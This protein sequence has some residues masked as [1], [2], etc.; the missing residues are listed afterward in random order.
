MENRSGSRLTNILQINTVYK[1]NIDEWP[2]C[3]EIWTWVIVLGIWFLI[4]H[5]DSTKLI[6]HT[7]ASSQKVAKIPGKRARSENWPN[8]GQKYQIPHTLAFLLLNVLSFEHEKLHRPDT[9]EKTKWACFC[10][11]GENCVRNIYISWI[12]RAPNISERRKC[13]TFKWKYPRKYFHKY[14]QI[15]F[16]SSSLSQLNNRAL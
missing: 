5:T 6:T 9:L 7:A 11:H 16:T 2:L 4:G 10:F 13:L 14:K 12:P 15:F 8:S 3:I 1:S